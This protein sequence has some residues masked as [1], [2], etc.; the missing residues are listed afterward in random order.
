MLPPRGNC[1]CA[2]LRFNVT[3]VVTVDY[4]GGSMV[5]TVDYWAR[6]GRAMNCL[7]MGSFTPGDT[8]SKNIVE[9][10]FLITTFILIGLVD[11]IP[12]SLTPLKSTKVVQNHKGRNI[13]NETIIFQICQS[14]TFEISTNAMV[15][16]F[17]KSIYSRI[18]KSQLSWV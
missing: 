18:L 9:I 14:H 17:G 11:W 4:S 2:G 16:W 1:V 13:S 8:R 10:I 12:D 15:W 3:V 5:V 7:P 6:F